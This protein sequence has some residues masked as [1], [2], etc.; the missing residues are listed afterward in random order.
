MTAGGTLGAMPVDQELE[1]EMEAEAVAGTLTIPEIDLPVTLLEKIRPELSHARLEKAQQANSL[2]DNWQAAQNQSDE[3]RRKRRERELALLEF[4]RKMEELRERCDRLLE[5]LAE[6]EY[7]ARIEME[8]AQERAIRLNNGK[9]AL[10]DRNGE[11]VDD[12][13]GRRLK[14]EDKIEAQQKQRADSETVE[15]RRTN[16]KRL[17]TIVQSEKEVAKLRTEASQDGKKITEAQK[18]NLTKE[19]EKK[20]VHAE[21]IVQDKNNRLAHLRSL[22]PPGAETVTSSV[23]QNQFT[24]S[25]RGN[26]AETPAAS[27]TAATPTEKIQIKNGLS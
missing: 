3:Q 8:K 15:E 16:Q 14:G 2:R 20:V 10:V 18:E 21:E 27:D 19:I 13:T 23:V 7:E 24:A 12:E 26:V 25:A 1:R 11:F 6:Q 9:C 5:Q 17:K 22:T 4:E